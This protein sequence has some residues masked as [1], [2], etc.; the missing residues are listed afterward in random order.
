MVK[1]KDGIHGILV[2]VK[3]KDGEIYDLMFL[4]STKRDISKYSSKREQTFVALRL[5]SLI[6]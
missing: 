6:I 3:K 1:F 4:V 2:V 5:N